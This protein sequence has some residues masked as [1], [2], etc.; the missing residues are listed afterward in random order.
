MCTSSITVITNRNHRLSHCLMYCASPGLIKLRIDNFNKVNELKR[1]I[2][3]KSDY[4]T[5][6][7]TPAICWSFTHHHFRCLVLSPFESCHVIDIMLPHKPNICHVRDIMLLCKPNIYHAS[8]RKA[9]LRRVV[10]SDT[11][12]P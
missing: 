2:I 7:E 4:Y 6:S 11:Y 8:F 9:I 3:N 10:C 12:N 1:L 5:S